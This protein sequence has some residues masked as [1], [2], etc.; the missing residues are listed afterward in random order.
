MPR[1]AQDVKL[2]VRR[3]RFRAAVTECLDDDGRTDRR[4][5][6]P[7]QTG[8][9]D[10]RLKTAAFLVIREKE[11]TEFRGGVGFEVLFGR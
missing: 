2:L 5:P 10:K 11:G 8:A 4:L 3:I 1:L 9:P 6:E 7:H